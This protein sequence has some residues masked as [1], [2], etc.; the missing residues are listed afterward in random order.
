MKNNYNYEE[1]IMIC[2]IALDM[3]NIRQFLVK[4]ED[5]TDIIEKINQYYN[6]N[7]MEDNVDLTKM[8]MKQYPEI[9]GENNPQL[10]N[11]MTED[12]FVCYCQERYPEIKWHSEVVIKYRTI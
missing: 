12:E 11:Y 7:P 10:F 1:S 4:D 2:E 8:F 3:L 6:N 9:F 5:L